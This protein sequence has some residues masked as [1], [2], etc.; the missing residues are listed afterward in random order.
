MEMA[1]F[2]QKY[3]QRARFWAPVLGRLPGVRAM[4][5]SGSLAQGQGSVHSDIDF[6]IIARPGRIWTARF[7]I[8]VTLK[9][10]RRLAKSDHHD[11]QICPNHFITEDQL[12]IVE[13][14]A[15][16][17]HLFAHNQP[18]YD[19]KGVWFQ[20]VRANREW[21][22]EF[23]E[24]FGVSEVDSSSNPNLKDKSSSPLK[25]GLSQLSGEPSPDLG[26]S[27]I[28]KWLRKIQIRRIQA[29]SES[30]LP[31]AKIVLTD[32]ELRFHPAPKNKK[33]S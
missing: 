28:E 3:T 2:L 20:F 27:F 18:L 16:S 9:L 17:A 19:P 30:Q 21:V 4:F 26:R 23:G 31:G 12:E 32:T 6:F 10:F 25:S 7:V 5:L 33:W 14:D 8:F 24:S 1:D 13:Q 11:G 15:Y 22:G 29:N